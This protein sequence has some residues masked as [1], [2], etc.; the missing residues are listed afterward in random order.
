MFVVLH[1]HF[2]IERFKNTCIIFLAMMLFLSINIFRLLDDSQAFLEEDDFI[3]QCVCHCLDTVFNRVLE[4][5]P[6]VKSHQSI[7][8]CT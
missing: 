7:L 8:H 3:S 4:I 6:W 5:L 2:F 1:S